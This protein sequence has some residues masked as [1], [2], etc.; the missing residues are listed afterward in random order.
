MI[1][2]SPLIRLDHILY[3]I[4]GLSD[5]IADMNFQQFCSSYI[6]IR[7]VERGL[8]IISEATRTLPDELLASQPTI[9]WVRIRGIGN[10]L[11]H[12]YHRLDKQAL[13]DIARNKLPELRDAIVSMRATFVKTDL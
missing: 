3:E 9:D 1:S 4:D 11:R 13:W 10:F 6:G 5:T 7:V 12:E 2:K 8:E